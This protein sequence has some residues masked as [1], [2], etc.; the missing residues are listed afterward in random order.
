MLRQK[1]KDAN[2]D[3]GKRVDKKALKADGKYEPNT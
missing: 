3:D 2:L 1:F